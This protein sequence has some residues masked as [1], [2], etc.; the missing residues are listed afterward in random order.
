M[1]SYAEQMTDTEIWTVIVFLR[2]IGPA[3]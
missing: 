1:E 3:R 2:S